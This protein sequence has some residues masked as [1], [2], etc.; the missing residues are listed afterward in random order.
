MGRTDSRCPGLRSAREAPVGSGRPCLHGGDALLGSR[1]E[2]AEKGPDRSR[3][4]PSTAV[5]HAAGHGKG[6]ARP[7]APWPDG[8]LRHHRSSATGQDVLDDYARR[9]EL[10]GRGS[11]PGRRAPPAP[12][13]ARS[14]LEART[15][16]VLRSHGAGAAGPGRRGR[17]DRRSA[18]LDLR[19]RTAGKNPSPRGPRAPSDVRARIQERTPASRPP[20]TLVTTGGRAGGSG[21][22]TGARYPTVSGPG[23]PAREVGRRAAGKGSRGPENLGPRLR[24]GRA[25]RVRRARRSAAEP[26]RC[27]AG[28]RGRA[29]GGR[30]RPARSRS[31]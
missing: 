9:F 17:R 19:P 11:P 12:R 16:A 30:P 18:R 10:Q 25:P 3:P 8:R 1:R 15:L 24:E 13:E 26:L 5:R 31:P 23:D 29:G 21:R 7:F 28:L 20:W 14:G 2:D 6:P 4:T 22:S 27:V